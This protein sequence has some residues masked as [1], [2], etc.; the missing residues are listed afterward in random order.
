[1]MDDWRVI[2]K[3]GASCPQRRLGGYH[4]ADTRGA[5]D[6]TPTDVSSELEIY[7]RLIGFFPIEDDGGQ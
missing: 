2:A 4:Q 7:K 6:C 1:M 3:G 5:E